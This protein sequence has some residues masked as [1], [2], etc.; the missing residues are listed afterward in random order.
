MF[1]LVIWLLLAYIG[2]RIFKSLVAPRQPSAS[3]PARNDEETVQDPVCKV[4]LAKQDAIVGTLDGTRH[5][6]CSMDCLD[7]FRD[8]LDH[9]H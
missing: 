5:Y 4:Y 2:F 8:Q 9:I 1:R 7:K 6:F 3:K